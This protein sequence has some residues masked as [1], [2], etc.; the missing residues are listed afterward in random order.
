MAAHLC[1]IGGVRAAAPVLVTLL[2]S[3]DDPT[4]AAAAAT[5]LG[6]IGRPQ[7]VG[8]LAAAT[9][10]FFP[11]QVRHA[12]IE[13]LGDLGVEAA[14]PVLT[15]HLSDPRSQIAEAAATSLIAIGPRGRRAVVEHEL[16]ARRGHGP[17]PRPP[18]GGAGLIGTGASDVAHQVL[19]TTFAVTA[20]LV[21][22]YFVLI[23]TSYLVLVVVSAVEFRGHMDR[24]DTRRQQTAGELTPGVSVIVPA[25]NEEALIVSSVRR[26]WRCATPSTRSSSSTTAA[27]TARCA[28]LTDAFDL[29][30]VPTHH[31]GEIPVAPWCSEVLV[32][33]N[34]RTRL[35]V[36]TKTNSGRSEADQRRGQHGPRVPRR[37]HR[38]RLDPRA[39]RPACG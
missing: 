5:A 1:G 16:R 12:A 24:K 31:P 32:P 26:C 6:K 3:H 35:V 36:V 25:F 14:V 7:D 10:H 22:A 20:P 28:V 37:H 34:G 9:L 17:G 13:A 38:R 19:E 39:R 27:P 30:P 11:F 29:V 2:E 8:A 18:Q 15:R 33:R 21:L 23:N 4:V